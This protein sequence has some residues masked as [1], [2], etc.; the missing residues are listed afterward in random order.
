M[1]QI[2]KHTIGIIFLGTPHFGAD[3]AKWGT[4][5]GRLISIIRQTNVPIV[6]VLRIDSEM[7]ASIQKEF[8]G[9]LRQR[10]DER[11]PIDVTCFYE[12]LPVRVFGLVS[13]LS[14]VQ[15]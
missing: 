10:I 14:R 13:S 9:V 2:E 12:E 6:E 5:C 8:Q 4:Y 15:N 3:A 7:L 11:T 1:R